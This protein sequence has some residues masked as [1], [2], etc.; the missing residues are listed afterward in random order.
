MPQPSPNLQQLPNR[1]YGLLQQEGGA[2]LVRIDRDEGQ[3]R[4]IIP[5]SFRRAMLQAAHDD[6]LHGGY[7]R[8]RE[9]LAGV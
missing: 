8:L 9:A 2:D 4:F 6:Q 7:T 5:K 1:P 3:P